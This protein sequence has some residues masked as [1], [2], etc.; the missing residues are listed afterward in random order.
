MNK[1][2]TREQI[3]DWS[4]GPTTV[5]L[6][7]LIE[8]ELLTIKDTPITDCLVAGNPTETHENLAELEAR[9]RVWGYLVDFLDGDWAYFEVDEEED[10]ERSSTTGY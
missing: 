1:E 7:E 8:Q 4:E 6:K 10:D 2:I 3:N 9:E 5:A